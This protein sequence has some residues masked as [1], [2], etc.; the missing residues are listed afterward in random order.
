MLHVPS[1]AT[2]VAADVAYNQIHPMLALSGPE[3]WDRWLASIDAVARLEPRH[4]IAGHKK[5]GAGDDAA[6]V[7][8]GTSSYIRDFAAAVAAAPSVEAVVETMRAT[9][10]DHGNLTTLVFSAQAAMRRRPAPEA[11]ARPR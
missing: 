11:L 4:V 2:V 5:P 6:E 9:Y 1:L 10:P 3:Q 7:L 8:H